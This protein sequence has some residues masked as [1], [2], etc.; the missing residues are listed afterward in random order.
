M[1]IKLSLFSSFFKKQKKQLIVP[2]SL[3]LKKIKSFAQSNNLTVFT[4]KE[5]FHHTTIHPITLFLYDNLRGIYIFESKDW[6]Y[7]DLQNATIQKAENVAPSHDSLAFDK[8]HDIIKT[9]FNELLHN[10]GVAIFN[11]LLMEN[12]SADE[13]ELL[14]TSL[15]A[16]L[17]KERIIF[18]D[19]ETV[20]IEKKLHN[21]PKTK[22]RLPSA[23]FIAGTLFVQYAIIKNEQIY[24]CNEEQISFID[25]TIKMHKTLCAPAKSGKSYTLLLKA[26]KELFTKERKKIILI[27]PT[28]VAKDILY[29]RF[30]E[31]IEHAIID[32]DLMAFE[33]LTPIELLNRHRTKLKMPL[34]EE[35]TIEKKLMQKSFFAAELILCDDADLLDEEFIAYL[36]HIQKKSDLLLVND[37]TTA[38]DFQFTT[39]YLPQKRVI[40]FY[41]TNPHAKA[42]HLVAKL[43]QKSAAEDILVICSKESREK[44]SD[45]LDGFISEQ[46]TLFDANRHIIEQH[47]SSLRL[48]TYDDMIELE[49]KD[50]IIMDTASQKV[51]KLHYAAN[52]ATQTLTILYEQPSK[53]IELLK[54]AYEKNRQE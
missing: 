20:E 26:I 7:S 17:P 34:Q 24:L 23:N 49:A 53:E 3:F 18:S 40:K 47:L 14:D 11:Y 2:D 6:S 42:L 10:D 35:L 41:E 16:A 5:I 39:S 37:N 48:V 15:Q 51:A 12:L 29:Q 31:L 4:H 28:T 50:V 36:K 38:Y 32:I 46:T 19:D 25:T 27:K 33:I 22:E 21:I 52:I 45:D 44:L 9:K 8:T 54:E 1:D 30:L 13:Y 43:L